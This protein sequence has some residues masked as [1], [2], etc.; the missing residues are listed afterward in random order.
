MYLLAIFL[1]P[2]A[3]WIRK[4]FLAALL[5]LFLSLLGF[6]PGVIHALIVVSSTDA[7]KRT[8]KLEKK[9]S[10]LIEIQESKAEKKSPKTTELPTKKGIDWSKV[11]TI[12]NIAWFF[13]FIFVVNSFGA[14]LD[15]SFLKSLLFLA[16]S[17]MIA[18]PTWK[19]LREKSDKMTR[20]VAA[21]ITVVLVLASSANA[22]E[23]STNPTV[24]PSPKPVPKVEVKAPSNEPSPTPEPTTKVEATNLPNTPNPQIQPTTVPNNSDEKQKVSQFLDDLFDLSDYADQS[25]EAMEETINESNSESEIYESIKTAQEKSYFIST[26]I[27]DLDIPSGVSSEVRQNLT[28]GRDIAR[29]AYFTRS[30]ALKTAMKYSDD[31]K[32]STLSKYKEE[33]ELSDKMLIE[34]ISYLQTAKTSLGI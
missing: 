33:L 21:V 11:L 2:I 3:V 6:I 18:P 12:T 15:G 24:S 25:F 22:Q 28:K 13:V 31:E 8:E 16:T 20:N 29:T 23:K 19:A 27:R 14:L 34:A 9:L 10:Q 1:P 32:P 4:G 17:A 30:D 26:K 5:N 7:D